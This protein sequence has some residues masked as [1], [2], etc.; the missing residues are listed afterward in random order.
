MTPQSTSPNLQSSLWINKPFITYPMTCKHLSVGLGRFDE[1]WKVMLS[2]SAQPPV[3]AIA[4]T[5]LNSQRSVLLLSAHDMGL[6]SEV[7]T[8]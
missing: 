8:E 6:N 1:R 7:I 2:L 5:T 3:L 4:A